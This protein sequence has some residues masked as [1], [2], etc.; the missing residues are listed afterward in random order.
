MTPADVLALL[1]AIERALGGPIREM[2]EAIV[3]DKHPELL[4]PPPE[5]EE[6]AII[7]EDVARLRER[8]GKGES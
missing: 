3:R 1:E 6:R 2:V 7:A 4:P 5:D 8:F